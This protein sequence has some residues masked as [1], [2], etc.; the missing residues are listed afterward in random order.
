M[1]SNMNTPH[2]IRQAQYKKGFIAPLLL[3]LIALILIGGGTYVYSVQKN[4]ENQPATGSVTL[5]QATSTMP[6]T[7][8]TTT[9]TQTSNSQ[10]VDWKIFNNAANTFEVKYPTDAKLVVRV[11]TQIE[12]CVWIQTKEGGLVSI[13]GSVLG[14][15]G[16]G[17]GLGVG[18]IRA[19]DT[20]TLGETQK[21]I[22][23]WK[24]V[25]NSWGYFSG[26]RLSEA[27]SVSDYGVKIERPE[28]PTTISEVQYQAALN[29][30]KD[31]I[32]TVKSY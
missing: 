25:D 12:S 7:K 32:A 18:N 17:P 6:T 20:I 9:T 14:C 16:P 31:I 10:T 24:N 30:A 21:T 27:I 3:A 28:P 29:S 4:Q 22:S 26:F 13:E 15:D 8:Q 11:D 23:G 2:Y 19:T 1:L 5:P